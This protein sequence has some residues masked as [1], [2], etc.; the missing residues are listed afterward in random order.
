MFEK[1]F[2][3]PQRIRGD[4]RERLI[5]PSFYH[6]GKN[7]KS[8]QID[9]YNNNNA[10]RFWQTDRITSDKFDGSNRAHI[11]TWN[12]VFLSFDV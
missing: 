7:D 12:V 3:Y 8:R 1:P 5:G 11:Q 10:V 4:E 9:A 6:G 2:P